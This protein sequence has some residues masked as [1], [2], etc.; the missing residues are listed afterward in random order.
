MALNLACFTPIHQLLHLIRMQF[1]TSCTHKYN[2]EWILKKE[3]SLVT[4]PLPGFRECFPTLICKT[5]SVHLMFPVGDEQW[6]RQ[7]VSLQGELEDGEPPQMVQVTHVPI[8]LTVRVR[9]WDG[10]LLPLTQ[11]CDGEP[12]ALRC[13]RDSWWEGINTR[14]VWTVPMEHI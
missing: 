13:W 10:F 11:C 2:T 12:E 4:T 9:W 7:S 1:T 6:G 8:Y 5:L 3:Q 14:V